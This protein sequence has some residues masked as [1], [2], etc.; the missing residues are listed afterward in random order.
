MK[1]YA[2][3]DLHL[4]YKVNREAM[5]DIHDY[6]DDWLILGGDIGEREEHLH[7]AFRIA[8]N[9]FKKVFWVPGNH[10]LWTLSNEGNEFKGVARYEHL[11]ELARSYGVL[12]PEDP[13]TLWQGEGGPVIIAPLFNLYDYSFRPKNVPAG[14]EIEWAM[15]AGILCND[16]NYIKP[17]PYASIPEWCDA[18]LKY[19]VEK[20]DLAANEHP[21]ARFVLINHFPLRYE[22]VRLWRIPRFSIW[23]GTTRT[24]D[25][26]KKYP[27]TVAVY[28]HL[29]IRATDYRDG[30]RFEEVSLGYPRHW[31]QDRGI[32]YYLREILPGKPSNI[33]QKIS[34]ALGGHS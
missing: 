15:E 23:C 1:L 2:L 3:S 34:S 13:F 31:R 24:E 5:E 11:V 25:W 27:V 30:V 22:H 4:H 32:N 8:T 10:E 28:G 12:T 19:S 21:D 9:R 14:K 16:E 6:P 33:I 17:E 7:Y 20:L 29:H 26:H 18:R